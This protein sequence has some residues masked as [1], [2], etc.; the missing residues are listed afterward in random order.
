M[1]LVRFLWYTLLSL[2]LFTA[3]QITLIGSLY[4]LRIAL[5]FYF[6]GAPI[7]GIPIEWIEKYDFGTEYNRDVVKQ[8]IKKWRGK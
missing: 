5:E 7:K 1:G 3:L 4:V 8:M 2:I 6:D